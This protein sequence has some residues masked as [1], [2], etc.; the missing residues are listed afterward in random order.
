MK[1]RESLR[2]KQLVKIETP[3]M[4]KQQTKDMMEQA[5]PTALNMLPSTSKE[6][7]QNKSQPNEPTVGLG[8]STYDI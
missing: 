8:P 3:Q 2:Q 1:A 5:D 6:D 7:S 4:V